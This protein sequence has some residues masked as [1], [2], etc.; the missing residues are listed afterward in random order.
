[1][2]NFEIIYYLN[3]NSVFFKCLKEFI[4]FRMFHFRANYGTS[5]ARLVYKNISFK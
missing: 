4:L 3:R 5:F 1:M 2:A